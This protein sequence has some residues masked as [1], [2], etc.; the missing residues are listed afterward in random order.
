M[1]KVQ[2]VAILGSLGLLGIVIEFV[3][4]KA[5]REDY[6]L[7]WLLTAVVL[8]ILSFWRGLL[9][10]LAEVVGIF[11]PPTALF[12]VGFGF[13]I[14]IL[15]QFSVVISRLATENKELAQSLSILRWQLTQLEKR[16]GKNDVETEVQRTED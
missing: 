4:R 11:Y 9:E 15:L 10:L 14:L 8:V 12:V 1:A 13:V 6:S 3:R 16:V 5:L 7:L 2:I